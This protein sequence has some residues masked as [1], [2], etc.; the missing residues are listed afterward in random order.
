MVFVLLYMTLLNMIILRAINLTFLCLSKKL[1]KEARLFKNEDRF[2]CVCF[3]L[4]N[5]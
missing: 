2:V 4:L 1:L 5:I 3:G